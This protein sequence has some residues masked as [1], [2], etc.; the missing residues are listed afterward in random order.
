V[1]LEIEFGDVG[2]DPADLLVGHRLGVEGADD[3]LAVGGGLDVGEG[4]GGDP[5]MMTIPVL[6]PG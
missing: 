3:P 6:R 5:G 1:R 2:E 4:R